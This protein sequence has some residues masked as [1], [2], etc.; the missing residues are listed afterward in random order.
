MSAFEKNQ[1]VDTRSFDL[2]QKM[3][4][5]FERSIDAVIG[6]DDEGGIIAWNHAAEEMFGWSRKEAMGRNMGDLIV[7]LEH[8]V[9]HTRG[10]S[11]YKKTGEGPVLGKPVRITACRRSGEEFPIELSIFPDEENGRAQKFY[12]FV[13]DLEVEEQ[14]RRALEMRAREAEVLLAVSGKLL[15]DT[16]FSELVHYCLDQVC[17]L[18]GLHAAHLLIAKGD[19]AMR[20]LVPTNIW[21]K[22]TVSL[23]DI[24]LVTQRCS[25]SRGEGLPGKAWEDEKLVV[26]DNIGENDALPRCDAFRASGLWSGI[27]LPVFRQG[28]IYA[29][30]EFYGTARIRVDA[31]LLRLVRTLGSQIGVAIQRRQEAEEREILR[32]EVAHRVGNSLTILASIYRRCAGKAASIQ[33]LSSEFLSRL[34]SVG[35][36]NHL[37]LEESKQGARLGELIRNSIAVL[38]DAES[39]EVFVPDIVVQ[40]H[41]V[42][43][44]SLVFNELATNALK[45]GGLGG[46]HANLVI[47]GGIDESGVLSLDWSERRHQS[48]E[49]IGRGEG[50]GSQLISNMVESRLGGSFERVISTEGCDV[51]MQLPLQN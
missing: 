25:F 38:P 11:H 37:S 21:S 19:G 28:E 15:E 18:T 5:L 36:A 10:L 9:A 23:E 45:Y 12:G 2:P 24:E 27:A 30:L 22:N 14:N 41:M 26:V 39:V 33:E 3:E 43:P 8:R 34:T 1:V 47:K 35:R 32:R 13:R 40:S 6:M 31:E 4:A 20:R 29:V 46:G 7:P 42:L 16:S 17:A 48:A 44:L 51:V 50:F 49:L